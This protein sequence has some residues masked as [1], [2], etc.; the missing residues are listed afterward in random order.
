MGSST[1]RIG[2]GVPPE[3]SQSRLTQVMRRS[4]GSFSFGTRLNELAENFVPHHG[5][6]SRGMGEV[7]WSCLNFR[8][9]ARAVFS[10][11]SPDL[12]MRRSEEHTSELQSPCNLV[13]RLLLEKNKKNRTNTNNIHSNSDSESINNF[14][15]ISINNNIRPSLQYVPDFIFFF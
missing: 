3:N 15:D 13:C 11:R 9:R 6:A 1:A 7:F 2:N 12:P 14:S 10:S 8:V 4:R 5:Q